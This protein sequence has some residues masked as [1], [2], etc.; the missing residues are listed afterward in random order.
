MESLLDAMQE[1]EEDPE[2]KDG[3]RIMQM[4]KKTNDGVRELRYFADLD[5]SKVTAQERKDA[6]ALLDRMQNQ[7]SEFWKTHKKPEGTIWD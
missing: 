2:K 7:L 5:K 1:S 4:L 3:I 6:L